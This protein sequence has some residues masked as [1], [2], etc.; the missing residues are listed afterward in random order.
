MHKLQFPAT[1]AAEEHTQVMWVMGT[2][3]ALRKAF[4]YSLQKVGKLAKIQAVLDSPELK[5]Q[6][7][8]DTCWLAC[9]RSEALCNGV[10]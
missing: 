6:K 4:H 3:L 10:F 2:L 5:V 9:E 7:P 1:D 8:S